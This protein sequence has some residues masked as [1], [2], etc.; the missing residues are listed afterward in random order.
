MPLDPFYPI[1]KWILIFSKG[2]VKLF[3]KKWQ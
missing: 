3:K 2:W 1:N